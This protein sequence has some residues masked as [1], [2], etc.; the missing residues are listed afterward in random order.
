MVGDEIATHRNDR[1]IR[2]DRGIAVRN[3][4]TWTVTASRRDGSMVADGKDGRVDLPADSVRDHVDLAYAVTVMGAKAA[5]C[6]T[7]CCSSTEPST[8]AGSTSA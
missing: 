2:I 4:A 8:C 3:R 5:R 1:A 6:N 7:P